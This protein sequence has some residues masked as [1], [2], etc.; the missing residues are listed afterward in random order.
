MFKGRPVKIAHDKELMQYIESRI[1]DDWSFFS[2]G[3]YRQSYKWDRPQSRYKMGAYKT[4]KVYFS[5]FPK[6]DYQG[7]HQCKIS[8]D[9][10]GN[11]NHEPLSKW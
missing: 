10:K 5:H 6:F 4:E 7:E 11:N 2:N 1:A 8:D 9:Y 3:E